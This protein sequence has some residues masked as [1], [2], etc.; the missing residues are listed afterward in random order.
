MSKKLIAEATL[1]LF[2][3]NPV[4]LRFE[5]HGAARLAPQKG[6]G[7]A[8]ETIA[9]PLCASEFSTALRHYP[10][11]FSLG[12]NPMPLALL[13]VEQDVN[14][15][16]DND[17][18]WREGSY[19][20]AYVRRYP[21]IVTEPEG[22]ASQLLAI[23]AASDRFIM[24]SAECE[25]G[26]RIYDKAGLPTAITQDAMNFCR[27]FS[28]D[29][30]ATVAFAQAIADAGLLVPNR[31]E[32]QLPGAARHVLDG[33]MTINEKAFREL[34]ART[35][36]KWHSKGWLDLVALHFASQQ[37]WQTL[38]DIY[39]LGLSHAKAVA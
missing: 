2:Y 39:A 24:P 5:E 1:P 18:K 20:P 30:L 37:N 11:A 38:L 29:Y 31:A 17:G 12:K 16:V 23:D 32:I 21:F 34:P 19:V 15:F 3:K 10:I 7:F 9:A 28:V 4:L 25:G 35:V 6:Y 8:A 36:M 22:G 26:E 13:G 27:A 33:F 14:L